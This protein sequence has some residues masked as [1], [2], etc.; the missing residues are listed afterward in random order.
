MNKPLFSQLDDLSSEQLIGG[1]SSKKTRSTVFFTAQVS[2]SDTNSNGVQ[3]VDDAYTWNGGW[4]QHASAGKLNN[5]GGLVDD[6]SA[7]NNRFST[8]YTS[9]LVGIQYFTSNGSVDL[10]YDY[11]A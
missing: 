11:G 7:Y 9:G 10:Y 8:P 1:K 5:G 6:T 3:D 2:W 4:K